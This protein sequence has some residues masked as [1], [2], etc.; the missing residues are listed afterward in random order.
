MALTLNKVPGFADL[1]DSTLDAEKSALGL[2]L[3]RISQNAAFGMVRLEVF[4]DVYKHGDEVPLPVSPIDGYGYSRSELMYLWVPQNTGDPSTGWASYREPWTMWYGVWN[5]NQETGKVFSEVGYR[6]NNDHKDRQA[7]T[8]DGLLQVFV[9]AQRQ[10]SGLVLSAEP[11]FQPYEASDFY[12]DRP[13]HTTMLKRLNGSAKWATVGTEV[14]YLGEFA[15]GATVPFPVSPVDGYEYEAAEVKWA[16][17]WRW[18]ADTQNGYP[19]VPAINKGQLQD[20]QASVDASGAVYIG[21]VNVK[22]ELSGSHSYNDGRIAVWAFC[23]RATAATLSAPASGFADTDVSVFMPGETARASTMAALSANINEAACTPEFFSGE[24]EHGETVPL[25]VSPIDGYTYSRAELDYVWDWK[26]TGLAGGTTR[27]SLVRG[28]IAPSTG[29]VSI[30]SY[31]FSS[32]AEYVTL[33]TLGTLR[34]I[35]VAR[36]EGEP[37]PPVVVE[38]RPPDFETGG[39]DVIIDDVNPTKILPDQTLNL[40]GTAVAG[41]FADTTI[42]FATPYPDTSYAVNVSFQSSNAVLS[43]LNKTVNGFTAR[44]TNLLDELPDSDTADMTAQRELSA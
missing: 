33:S 28:G 41:D 2:H 24:Y 8:N 35:T 31:R 25:P 10:Q 6:G 18:T 36:R 5:V 14:I 40:P 29:V 37:A 21:N 15:H 23:Q 32:G 4:S 9:V 27:L 43:I 13:F 17:S 38:V 7:Q 12:V 44:V 19:V 42:T 30:S 39:G 34:V 20:W 16:T 22:Y 26:D 3:A 1:P 11:A